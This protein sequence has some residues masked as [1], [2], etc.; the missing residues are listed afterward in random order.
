MHYLFCKEDVSMTRI[1][2]LFSMKLNGLFS[3]LRVC[4]TR[5]V[6]EAL[7]ECKVKKPNPK[8]C[9]YSVSFGNG[10]VCRHQARYGFVRK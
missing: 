1:I 4:S 9:E 10:F 8:Y 3:P 7:F 2:N 5:M 6:N